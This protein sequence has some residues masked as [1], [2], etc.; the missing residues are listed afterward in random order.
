MKRLE[1]LGRWE[2][3]VASEKQNHQANPSNKIRTNCPK[4]GGTHAIKEGLMGTSLRRLRLTYLYCLHYLRAQ[5]KKCLATIRI[6]GQSDQTSA[7]L[8]GRQSTCKGHSLFHDGRKAKHMRIPQVYTKI[9]RYILICA[10]YIADSATDLIN[11][12]YFRSK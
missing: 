4:V 9:I 12:L 2:G 1:E 3:M 7:G 5:F 8:I 11:A 10:R 6:H